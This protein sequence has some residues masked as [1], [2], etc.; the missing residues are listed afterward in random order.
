MLLT[1]EVLAT[2]VHDVN[3]NGVKDPEEPALQGW[4][5]F[6][7]Y[8]RN[9]VPDAGEPSSVTDVDGEALITGVPDNTWD[10]RQIL[11]P[12]FAPSPGFDEFER[13]RV[14]DGEKV[15]V[16]FLNVETVGTGAVQGTVWNDVGRDGVRDAADAGLPGWTVFLDLNDD[17]ALSPG[18]PSTFTD[19]AGFYG[20]AGLATG[21]YR[22]REITP[23]GW[24]P[25]VGGDAGN[26]VDVFAGRTTVA[27][28][29]NFNVTGIADVRGTVWNDVNADG[30][31]GAGDP[32]LADW[33]VF[34]DVNHDGA[35]SFGERT[36]A[37]DAAGVYTISSVAVGTYE[38]A[39]V[40]KPGWNVS[41]GHA[42]S[43]ILNVVHEG[44]NRADFANFTPTL[45]SVSGR[46]WNDADGNGAIGVAE[47]GLSGWT[48]FIDQDADGAAG[49][50]EPSALS[51]AAGNY[52]LAGVPIG[53]F[54]VRA[55]PTAGWTPTAPG[56]GMQLVTVLNGSNV[57]N[58]NFGN[59]QRTDGTI[60]GVAFADAD[61]DGV[62]D[63]GERG[64]GGIPVYLDL[65][66]DGVRDPT[67][68]STV[69]S[70]DLFYTPAV[71]EAGNYQFTHLAA[72]VYA[73]RQ[74]LP[75]ELSATP[76]AQRTRVIDLAAGAQRTD[77]HFADVYC[78]N[79]IHGVVFD[80]VNRNHLQDPGEAGIP[81]VTVY[82]DVN[83]NDRAGATEPRTVTDAGGAY[84][85]TPT[86]PPAPTSS[87]RSTTP[88][89]ATPTRRRSTASSGPPASA[90]RPSATSPRRSSRPH[91]PTGRR[92]T[93]R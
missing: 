36:A 75:D 18:E 68:P 52:A 27:D 28:F 61:K 49:A 53:S 17:R 65:D 20:F 92:S 91:W 46:V 29:G 19:A 57:A 11:E 44:A 5:V 71:N 30:V 45:G 25:T 79:E 56:T 63:P 14:R 77:V 32:G 47:G 86:L 16:R 59:K 89:A 13:V 31:R 84:S 1:G 73:V 2:L 21:Q 81:G 87:A 23:A 24:D 67:E 78:P 69:T 22:V 10:V 54:V 9:G 35:P 55:A 6:V 88:A 34:L 50:G 90:T 26:N 64:L 85:S 40:L 74:V 51:D 80:D 8:D 41:P 12:G 72:G 76:P 82:I 42:T 58:V 62:R 93:T 70:A 33:T 39:Q 83:R 43:V 7:D 4:S 66:N 48:V 37:T 15:E 60:G 3:G 38:V